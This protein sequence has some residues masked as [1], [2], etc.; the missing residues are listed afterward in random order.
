MVAT[1][2]H[3]ATPPPAR[4][5]SLDAFR[6]AVILLMASGGLGLA[7]V[8]R[9][10]PESD[11]LR[12]LG[13]QTEHAAWRGCTVWDLIQPAFMFMVGVALPWSIANRRSR[14]DA[15]SAMLGHALLRA[16][17]LVL[18]GVFLAS[19]WSKQTDWNFVNVLAQIG[20]GYPFLFLVAFTGAR[21]QW[22]AAG[23]ILF[24]TWLAFVM[25]QPEAAGS[26]PAELGAWAKGAN[27][28]AT[29]DVHLLNW[30]PRAA[31]Y[32]HNSGG[33]QTLN[34]APSLATMIFGLLAGNLLRS[35]HGLRRKVGG[36]AFAGSALVVVGAALD[37]LGLCPLVKRIWTPSFALYSAGWV[38]IALAAFVAVID[39]RGWK[40]WTFPLV[41]AGLNPIALYFMWQLMSS[42]IRG[43]IKTH[44]GQRVF[45][46]FGPGF[47]PLAERLAV[48]TV[49]W[50]ILWWM[51]RR[52]IFLKI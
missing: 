4:L 8:A 2:G 6:G 19:A 7:E 34:F 43:S 28:A 45:E 22:I 10:H 25:H 49:L 20:L 14:G 48:L 42:S 40:R 47:T 1:P 35:E 27:L 21:T 38:A 41:V 30:F 51:Y 16:A 9:R 33:Y 31:A 26:P 37:A 52:K 32:T 13:E 36:L 3:P 5:T 11:L 15:F 46:I 44:L 29:V 24:C 50:L 39:W 23:A 18:L 17:L 12:F